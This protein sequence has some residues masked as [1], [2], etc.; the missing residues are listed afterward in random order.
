MTQRAVSILGATGSVGQAAVDL[1]VGAPERFRME[2][3]A[4][5]R[6][7]DG[8]AAAARRS[9]AR[10][11]AIADPLGYAPLKA[12]LAGLNTEVAA[13]D[14]AVLEA[15]SRAADVVVA[16]I[17]GL[18]GL[19]P[20]LAACRPGVTV[21]LANKE[22]LVSAGEIVLGRA[23]AAGATILPVD[24]E[25]SALF[26][27]YEPDRAHAVERLTLTASGGPF[28]Q[29]SR[30]KM[31]AVRLEDAL[32]HPNWEMGAKITIDSAT[33][34]N[35]GLELIEAARLF[36]LSED[37]I[38]IVVHPQSVIHG[39]VSYRDGSVM[40]QLGSPDMATPIAVALA[41]PDRMATPVA[42]LDLA[43]L[44][45]LTFE[46]P[47]PERFPALDLARQALRDGGCR[48]AVL[49]AANE[50]AVAAFLARRIG[51]LE[52]AAIVTE[53]LNAQPASAAKSLD[54]VLVVDAEARRLAAAAIDR[55]AAA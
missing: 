20:T 11:V 52:I 55:R 33:M 46:A 7:V 32:K 17:V 43:R 1:V 50:A 54:D 49:N 35:K 16:A 12:A 13:G 25:H 31:A 29:W 10:F 47:D 53:T 15:A 21:A 4:A 37:R 3:L 34:M 41:W 27:A 28:R 44:G 38:D 24:S 6:D 22:A 14:D 2:A 23:R 30:E 8:L 42:R 5:G 19:P 9:G 18:A 48:P 39:M 26:Q 45:Q 36:P 40:A 51:Y